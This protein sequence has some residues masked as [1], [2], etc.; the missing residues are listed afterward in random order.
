[1]R[2]ETTNPTHK[3]KFFIIKIIIG[4]LALCIHSAKPALIPKSYIYAL[5]IFKQNF[6]IVVNKLFEETE[7]HFVCSSPTK[8]VSF[9]TSPEEI[10]AVV[11]VSYVSSNFSYSIFLIC[12]EDSAEFTETVIVQV[13]FVDKSVFKEQTYMITKN[14]LDTYFFTDT[15]YS[16]KFTLSGL[17]TGEPSLNYLLEDKD[18]RLT[19]EFSDYVE[20]NSDRPNEKTLICNNQFAMVINSKN[21]KI[22]IKNF[23]IHSERYESPVFTELYS[24]KYQDVI[25][26]YYCDSFRTVIISWLKEKFIFDF[27]YFKNGK[28]SLSSFEIEIGE[29]KE[30]LTY[31]GAINE[32][33]LV[34]VLIYKFDTDSLYI[35]FKDQE[36]E[37]EVL[38]PVPIAEILK[39]DPNN[40]FSINAISREKIQ[41][42]ERS[43]V[44]IYLVEKKSAIKIFSH[45]NLTFLHKR[46]NGTS[47]FSDK[48]NFYVKVKYLK[49]ALIYP[50]KDLGWEGAEFYNLDNSKI[51]VKSPNKEP[52]I[53]QID[54]SGKFFL[55]K[56]IR[57]LR[58]FS[59][60]RN[61]KFIKYE[62]CGFWMNFLDQ[63]KVKVYFISKDSNQLKIKINKEK[64]DT[65]YEDVKLLDG[66]VKIGNP[67]NFILAKHSSKMIEDNSY[68]KAEI[69][70][71][72]IQMLNKLI[73]MNFL[74][75]MV[76]I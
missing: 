19:E 59:L 45:G 10:T 44:H 56:I 62:N 24:A 26:D 22:M 35:Y 33:S 76:I 60:N 28:E 40:I 2:E 49:H 53:I 47:L 31:I 6:T 70:K 66:S 36:N 43:G 38:D 25:I 15:L 64:K 75:L 21:K 68:L 58:N 18:Y 14:T 23:E 37:I 12:K 27:N 30:P 54:N 57:G 16:I 74:L 13:E 20:L 1:M 63:E 55:K 5:K 42:V 29:K 72:L 48:E 65:I 7:T 61:F 41:I 3:K 9:F 46:F 69:K 39:I 52:F 32:Y 73:L 11:D 67:T 4:L 34:L 71:R 51:M 17:L 8:G 50:L